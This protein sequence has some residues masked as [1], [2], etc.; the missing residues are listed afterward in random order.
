M[1]KK[2]LQNFFLIILSLISIFFILEL[3]IRFI[4]GDTP[5]SAIDFKNNDQ[6][7]PY[8]ED[9]ILG[10]KLNRGIYFSRG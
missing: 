1:I 6:P 9:K 5:R 7:I 4:F 3:S 2:I 10:W 8:I